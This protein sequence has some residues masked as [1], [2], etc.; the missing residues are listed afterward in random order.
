M[1]KSRQ[2]SS[3]HASPAST[4]RFGRKRS[5]P[6]GSSARSFSQCSEA[7]LATR[8][9]AASA[10]LSVMSTPGIGKRYSLRSVM[11]TSRTGLPTRSVNDA[12]ASSP[13]S[14]ASTGTPSSEFAVMSLAV[15]IATSSAARPSASSLSP[16]RANAGRT[17]ASTGCC[18]CVTGLPS[19]SITW[20][21]RSPRKP[22]LAISTRSSATARQDFT[23]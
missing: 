5:I 9:E 12:A 23:G 20:N 17:V 8:T 10:Q 19:V 22:V 1:E 2:V 15:G 6:N 21:R 14:A 18:R 13:E 16:P 3:T 7:V 4:V 11:A